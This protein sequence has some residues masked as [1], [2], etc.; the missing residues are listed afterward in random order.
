MPHGPSPHREARDHVLRAP[1]A[2]VPG[3]PLARCGVPTAPVARELS[4]DFKLVET[5]VEATR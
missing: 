3:I 2:A 1:F 5:S 4:S